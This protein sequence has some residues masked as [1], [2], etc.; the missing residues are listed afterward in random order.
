MGNK[1]GITLE[2][3]LRML[4]AAKLQIEEQQEQLSA[5]ENEINSHKEKIDFQIQVINRQ[6][7]EIA[8]KDLEI[9]EKMTKLKAAELENTRLE[10]ELASL[11][12]YRFCAHSEKA[13]NQPW[14]FDFEDEEFIPSDEEIEASV[15]GE[16]PF[17][18]TVVRAY[19]RRKCGKKPLADELP[20]KDIIHDIADEDK[21]CG[22]GK[23]LVKI[24]EDVSER[25]HI[26]PAKIY[27]ERHIYPKYACRN[28]EGSGDEDKPVFRQS[29]AIK[30]II[31][32]SIASPSLLSFVFINKY[33]NY[34]P[35]YRQSAAFERRLISISRAD[36]SNWQNQVYEK[37]KPLEKLL[38]EHIKTGNV[39]HMDETT[40]KVLKYDRPEE[41]QNRKKSYMWL[42]Q[43][44]PREKSAVLYQYFDSRSS[45]YIKHFINGFK[46]F[47]QTDEYP[48]YETALQEHSLLYPDDKII[49]VA[50]LA[51]VRRKFH[52]AWL[53][54]KSKGAEK[55]INYIKEIYRRENSLREMNLSDK[56]LVSKRKEIIKPLFDEFHRW[57][58]E[59]QPQVPESL[60]F[61]R[62]IKYAL[63]AWEHLLNYIDCP[64]IYLD[65]SIAERGIKPFVMGRKNWLFCGSEDGARSS[66]FLYSLIECAKINN[67]NPEE[68]L[69]S[70]FELAADTT[71]WTDSNWSELL[72]WNIKLQK[73]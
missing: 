43:G 59:I 34:M 33:C 60:K 39:M 24:G 4:A 42:A 28:C 67:I 68:Y 19:K 7:Q 30:N 29:P 1:T 40:V 15:A 31:Q 54:G 12:R 72:P 65:N 20:R 3:A 52:D 61:G 9:T 62:A 48:G 8:A 63:S 16:G 64:E 2:E 13:D 23:D 32:K 49:H 47:L 21:H 25:L 41:H 37:L 70:I 38:I 50:C 51:H 53:N 26:E 11:L 73:N 58:L 36:M 14:L 45:K 5:K 22:C 18:E 55:A 6:K 10:E 56:Q 69:S 71:D 35:Y 66:C 44:G 17:K 27:V 46:G 57:L